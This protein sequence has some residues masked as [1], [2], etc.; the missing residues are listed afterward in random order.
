MKCSVFLLKI[1]YA[2]D[3]IELYK[4]YDSDGSDINE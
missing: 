1:N 4:Y 2:S 3:K